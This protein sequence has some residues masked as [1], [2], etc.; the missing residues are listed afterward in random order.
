MQY[1]FSMEWVLSLLTS[2]LPLTSSL[3]YAPVNVKPQG[4]GGGAYPG[5]LTKREVFDTKWL[6][7]D[8]KIQ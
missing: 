4:R 7:I 5:D 3:S 8:D 2:S 1:S 6:P